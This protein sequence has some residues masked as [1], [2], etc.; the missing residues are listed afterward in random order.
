VREGRT[1]RAALPVARWLR[2]RLR[3]TLAAALRAGWPRRAA[4]HWL[5]A[6]RHAGG[7]EQV[8]MAATQGQASLGIEHQTCVHGDRLRRDE[9]GTAGLQTQEQGRLRASGRKKMVLRVVGKQGE[10]LGERWQGKMNRG[11][12]DAQERPSTRRGAAAR[13]WAE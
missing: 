12:G 5:A 4:T 10:K 1:R 13:G 2:R 7:N 8:A 11:S 6:G 3:A 9:L